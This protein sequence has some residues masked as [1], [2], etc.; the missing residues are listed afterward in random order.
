MCCEESV[1]WQNRTRIRNIELARALAQS[2]RQR[3]YVVHK[4]LVS[5][6]QLRVLRR[7]CVVR[8]R[9]L[10]HLDNAKAPQRLGHG[11]SQGRL[12]QQSSQRATRVL[13]HA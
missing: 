3:L 7:R 13:Q 10:R 5:L 1:C 2:R 9:R 8:K 11:S 6:G 12:L 4:P